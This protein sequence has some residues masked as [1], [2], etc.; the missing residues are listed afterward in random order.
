MGIVGIGDGVPSTVRIEDS[1][2]FKTSLRVKSEDPF[3]NESI[4][5]LIP[6]AFSFRGTF[7]IIRN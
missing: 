6:A 1:S 4:L 7:P 5:A 3:N 2:S